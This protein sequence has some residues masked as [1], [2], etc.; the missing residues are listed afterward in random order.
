MQKWLDYKKVT[1]GFPKSND[2][3]VLQNQKEKSGDFFVN[4]SQKSQDTASNIR[5][6]IPMHH[7]TSRKKHKYIFTGHFCSLMYVQNANFAPTTKNI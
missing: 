6:N 5:F 7:E 3:K 2:H 1:I 4:W